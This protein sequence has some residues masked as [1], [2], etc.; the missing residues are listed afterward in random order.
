MRC[1]EAEQQPADEEALLVLAVPRRF[2]ADGSS[3]HDGVAGRPTGATFDAE[4]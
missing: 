1:L 4:V 2:L 3:P